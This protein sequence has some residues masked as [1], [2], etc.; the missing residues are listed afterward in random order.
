MKNKLI[1]TL[2]SVFIISS[3]SSCSNDTDE[4]FNYQPI[5]RDV[6]EVEFSISDI[7]DVNTRCEVRNITSGGSVSSYD[8]SERGLYSPLYRMIVISDNKL[9]GDIKFAHT[10]IYYDPYGITSFG[11]PDGDVF[12]MGLKLPKSA[13]PSKIE[14]IVYNNPMMKS[15]QS[16]PTYSYFGNLDYSLDSD[17]SALL[18]EKYVGDPNH[19]LYLLN[20]HP[21]GSCTF[22]KKHKVS[23]ENDWS[24]I[25]T[26][27]ILKRINSLIYVFHKS[28]GNLASVTKTT[29]AY[30]LSKNCLVL[31]FD[32]SIDRF[33]ND[34]GT[35]K[36][37]NRLKYADTNISRYDIVNEKSAIYLNDFCKSFDYNARFTYTPSDAE[38]PTTFYLDNFI[39]V[40]ADETKSYPLDLLTNKEVRYVTNMVYEEDPRYRYGNY[41]N[42]KAMY[43]DECHLHYVSYPLP[44]GGIQRNKIYV[45]LV[46]LKESDVNTWNIGDIPTRAINNKEISKDS[47][48]ILE[49]DMDEPLPFELVEDTESI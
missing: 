9:I 48:Q 36:I 14:L 31:N 20:I 10:N 23:L 4:I 49:F 12:K 19:P 7:S 33:L 37:E 18:D 26:E 27:I 2:I 35:V 30:E 40:F 1:L 38:S 29:Y 13:D 5:K 47:Y 28:S 15:Y 43:G 22:F 21:C 6:Y 42:H 24:K 34:D 8:C 46:D 41:L 16:I 32:D 44:E 17:A 39:S 11:K 25:D 3:I 45:Y